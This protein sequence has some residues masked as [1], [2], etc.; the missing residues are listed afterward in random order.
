MT[1][2]IGVGASVPKGTIAAHPANIPA[3]WLECDGAAISRTDYAGLF[4]EIG[5]I[6]GVGDGATTFNLPDLRGEFVRGLDNGRGVDIGRV[7]GG[8]QLDQM[9]QITGSL[10]SSQ[11]FF[12][13]NDVFVNQGAQ[14]GSRPN[15]GANTTQ[16][17]AFDS[18]QS[19]G[20]RAGNETRPRNVAM[21]QCIKY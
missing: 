15:N 1:G 5:T 9:Q 10:S 13:G 11:V 2:F 4:A 7:L 20:A 21:Y 16:Q 6:Y 19:P 3:G 12:S 17:I 18:A 14:S 8:G